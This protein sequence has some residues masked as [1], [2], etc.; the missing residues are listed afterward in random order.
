M[1]ALND[2]I[3]SCKVSGSKIIIYNGNE[4]PLVVDGT[5]KNDYF[6]TIYACS[7]YQTLVKT[8]VLNEGVEAYIFNGANLMWPGVNNYEDLG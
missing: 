4:Y 6:P 7:A 8:L 2:K 3:I 1:L 5:G